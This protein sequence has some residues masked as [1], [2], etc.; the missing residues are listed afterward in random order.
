MDNRVRGGSPIQEATHA[1]SKETIAELQIDPADYNT[2]KAKCKTADLP[3]H[4]LVYGLVSFSLQGFFRIGD[5][6]RVDE[7]RAR[8]RDFISFLEQRL[9][10]EGEDREY[11]EDL[12]RRT[13][14]D[15][16]DAEDRIR[17]NYRRYE[18]FCE[19]LLQPLL[20]A[21]EESWRGSFPWE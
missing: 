13:R 8:L 4:L 6:T 20:D 3:D 17:R 9:T 5:V 7:L 11:V 14:S 21:P 2:F 15:L 10:V 1:R 19:R 16:D 18:A 12:I